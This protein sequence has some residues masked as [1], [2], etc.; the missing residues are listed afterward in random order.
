MR[1][2]MLA[3]TGLVIAV[4][5][6]SSYGTSVVEVGKTRAQ[7]A[8][9]S[10]A[11]PLS[12]A[13]GQTARAVATLKD[14]NGTPLTDRVVAWYTS[15]ASIASVSDSGMIAAVAPGTAVVS[16][17]SE[18][19]SAQASMAV[20]PPLPT[21]IATVSVAIS[22]PAVLIGQTAVATVT[23][24]DSS[25]NPI[26]GRVV[27]WESSDISV[28]TVQATG[29]VK[30]VGPGN[31]M[32]KASSE[33]KFNSSRLS[34]S[35]PAPIP[36]ASIS[37]SPATATLLQVGATVQLAATTFDANNNVLTGRVIGWSSA[38]TSIA[39]V[40]SSGLVT[41]K[42]GGSVSIVAASEG[43]SATAAVTVN[44]P[45]PV[46]VASV[47]VSPTSSNL[48]IGG[49][50]QL[51][52]VT[53][54]ASNNV[55]TGRVVTW[56]SANAGIASV[57]GSGLV[58]AVS[59]GTTQITATSEGKTSSAA[60]I[61]VS[62]T[63]P[64]PVAS[65]SVS[66][67]LSNLQIGGTAQLSAVTRD[68]SNNVLTGR[69]V[70]WASANAGIA[71]VNGSGFV[72]ALG[73]GTTQIT[74]ISEGKSGAATINVSAPAPLPVATVSVS[75][76]SASI[77]VSGTLQL[78]AVPRDASGNPLA[79]RLVT[80]SSQNPSIASV[81][82]SGVVT[83]ITA[84]GPVTITA[85]SETQVGSASITV[86]AAGSGP[87]WRGHEPAGMT[88]VS[89]QPFSAM[90]S[91]GWAI[92]G[93]AAL[94]SDATGPLSPG[95]ALV[96]PWNA[97]TMGGNGIGQ[98]YRPFSGSATTL[99]VCMWLKFSANWQG[100]INISNKIVYPFLGSAGNRFILEARGIGSAPLYVGIALQG[101]INL[102]ESFWTGSAVFRRGQWDMVEIIM[103]SNT[104]GTAD[105]QIDVYLNG[106]LAV[107]RPGIQFTSGTQGWTDQFSVD[108]VWSTTN[109]KVT[110]DMD[111]R[112][113]QLYL[114]RK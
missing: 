108:P 30:A 110:S 109:D 1:T 48:Q 88:P 53:R 106:T 19:V 13:A 3:V 40:S 27:T 102:G 45:A 104:A 66:P 103:K 94:R 112:F 87:V 89:D 74:A 5:A 51:S 6:C 9:V 91:D 42:A 44:A 64:V 113:D 7:V 22:P 76:A 77:P 93:A 65:V 8:S 26:S 79:G 15:S 10:I 99:Y 55:L 47:S 39:S 57:N 12:L 16:A 68:A 71:S 11:V 62:A 14:A 52:A 28:A 80:W 38:N 101:T 85:T 73:A 29:D 69:V 114:S 24:Q 37:V 23:L 50:A 100:G 95:S 54:D 49:T 32:I 46:P 60:T 17:V 61:T 96:V 72:T 81:T 83:G 107:S 105:G 41:A 111:I 63:A 90:P 58:T 56:A 18:G 34:V 20:T 2:F 35:A 84:G 75:P 25:G 70:T 97:G 82:S 33:G 59:A 43:Q 98:A 67:T 86:T 92:Q 78:S 4:A 21:P 31:A 36:V